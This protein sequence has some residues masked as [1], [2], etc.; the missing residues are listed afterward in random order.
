MRVLLTNH[1]PLEGSG[2][3]IY[4]QN[5][6]REL[7]HKGHDAIVIAPGH[8][9][10]SGFPFEVHTILFS[11]DDPIQDDSSRLPFNFPCFT[12]HPL[13]TTTYGDL[14]AEQRQAYVDAFVHATT[15]VV[16]DFKP[17]V[18]HAQ[19]LWVSGYAA[20]TTGLPY[21]ATAHGTDLMGI[22]KYKEWKAIALEGAQHA[23]AII[24]IS[25]QVAED[26]LSL[27]DIPAGNIRLVM[28]GFDESIFRVQTVVKDKI[29]SSYGITGEFEYVVSFVGK[30]TDFKG[31]DVLLNAAAIY[32]QDLGRVLTLIVGD[33]ELR[34]D[35][36]AQAQRLRL[37]GVHFLGHQP[38]PGVAKIYNLADVST[39]PSRV[40]P[41]GLVAIEAMACGTP[42]VATN[43]GGLPDFIHDGVGVLVDVDDAERLAEAIMA[44]IRSDAKA[45]K[46]PDA[47]RYALEG[48]SWSTQVDKMIAVYEECFKQP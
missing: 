4:T 39:V 44:E 20:H 46:G 45:R 14:S 8:E 37:M 32:E 2:S 7:T 21:V 16:A 17:D 40:E 30:L 29:L 43:E 3:G 19:H 34:G 10:H 13:S 6:A 23:A 28:N 27:Y 47:A 5:V 9:A 42:V 24:V 31:V 35:L 1:F 12:T 15:Q 36:E 25:K 41:F 38:Q 33:G 26:T 11:P 18:I 48:F 22:R